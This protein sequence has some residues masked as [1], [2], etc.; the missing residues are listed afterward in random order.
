MSRPAAGNGTITLAIVGAI[1]IWGGNNVGI[2]VLVRDW[3][4]LFTGST[5]FLFSGAFL[6]LFL[7]AF[8]QLAGPAGLKLTPLHRRHLWLR[9]GTSLAA[10]CVLTHWCLV[11]IPASHFSLCLAASPAWALL[12]EDRFQFRRA[13]AVRYL[14]IVMTLVGV[15]VLLW[16]ALRGTRGEW[17]G[18]L[19][20]VA[21]GI[22]WVVYNQQCRVLSQDGLSGLQTAGSTMWR[23]GAIIAIPAVIDL[24]RVGPFSMTPLSLGIQA[25][26]IIGGGLAYMLWNWSLSHWPVSR[27]ALVGNLNPVSTMVTAWL[28]VGEKLY[29]NFFIALVL[30]LGGV[31]LG[32]TPSKPNPAGPEA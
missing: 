13:S 25:Y 8:P 19:L 17:F 26:C 21:S 12:W 22:V 5:R 15:L 9:G 20:A 3:P 31:L 32:Q 29:S 4:L 11:Y 28:L 14:G 30:I 2:K 6:V 27:V 24:I 7:K 1:L 18:E 10:Y 23:A 16:P